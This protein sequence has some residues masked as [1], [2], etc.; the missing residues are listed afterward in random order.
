[1]E[2]LK[3]ICPLCGGEVE[4]CDTYDSYMD[5]SAYVD[6]C[7]G[8]CQKCGEEV[9]YNFVFPLGEPKVVVIDHRKS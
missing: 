5:D 9:D 1:M 7:Y 3:P 6:C 8:H 2:E 4:W